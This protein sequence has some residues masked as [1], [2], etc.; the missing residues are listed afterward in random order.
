DALKHCLRPYDLA[1]RYGG[2]EFTVVMPG[3]NPDTSMVVAERIRERVQ[4][5]SYMTRHG[6]ERHVTV[7]IGCATYPRTAE[8]AAS[9]IRAADSA[10]YDAKRS[11]R[12]RTVYYSGKFVAR[13]RHEGRVEK[14]DRWVADQD[15][16]QGEHLLGMMGP[17]VAELARTLPLSN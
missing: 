4:E 10:L 8:D 1:A 2:E 5:S 3:S 6:H 15:R 17:I 7:S 11:G 16:P 14:L 12:N 9:L 13:V